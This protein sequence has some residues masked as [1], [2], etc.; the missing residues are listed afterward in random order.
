MSYS[1]EAIYR[2]TSWA[3]MKHSTALAYLQEKAA[4]GQ[5]IIRMS[6]DSSRANQVLSYQSAALK[7]NVYVKNVTEISSVLELSSSI[8]QSVMTELARARTSLTSVASGT[9]GDQIRTTLASDI[10]NALEHIVSLSNTQRLGQRLFGGANST[11]DP[12]VVERDEAG[13]IVRV[14]Y[15]GSGEEQKV[16][17]VEGLELSPYLVGDDLFRF[18]TRRPPEFLGSTGAAVGAGSSSVRGDVY[19]TVSGSPGAWQ[20]SIDGGLSSVIV[21][22]AETNVPVINSKTGEVLYVDATGIGQEGVEPIRVPGTYDIFN[23]LIHARDILNNSENLPGA[24]VQKMLNATVDA[25]QDVEKKLVNAFPSIGGR[26]QVLETL[27]QSLESIGM[28]TEQE[29]SRLRD[30]DITQ[31]AIDLSRHQLLYEMSLTAAAK[32]FSMSLLD[33]LK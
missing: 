8:V 9:T 32:M 15:Q 23:V 19:L 10:N 1:M 27:K 28:S 33:L 14:I 3:I 22:G 20:L 4:T 26:I 18:D 2:S 16:E 13:N 29:I 25:M 30:A 11:Q 17:V 31:I 24:V 5:D 6:D 21:T 7:N 12:Y